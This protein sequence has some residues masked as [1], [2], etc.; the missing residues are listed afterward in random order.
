MQNIL[1]NYLCEKFNYSKSQELSHIITKNSREIHIDGLDMSK[2]FC[3]FF[4]TITIGFHTIL[5]GL[6]K[7]KLQLAV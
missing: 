2:A 7:Y 5:H 4:F 3:F 1:C 6:A